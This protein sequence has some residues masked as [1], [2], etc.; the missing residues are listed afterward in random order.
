MCINCQ[1]NACSILGGLFQA[2]IVSDRTG[3]EARIADMNR[4]LGNVAKLL[5]LFLDDLNSESEEINPQPFIDFFAEIGPIAAG[6]VIQRCGD[7]SS[8]L[9]TI[10]TTGIAA[11]NGMAE[12]GNTAAKAWLAAN[13]S[14]I[15]PPHGG[16]EDGPPIQIHIITDK[17]T[18]RGQGVGLPFPSRPRGPVS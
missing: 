7:F 5:K 8:A 14:N 13:I 16:D 3:Q 9:D 4:Q 1:K 10:N 15:V 12:G 18:D 6:E 11:M 17:R 2:G